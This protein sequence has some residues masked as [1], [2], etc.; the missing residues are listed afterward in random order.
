MGPGLAVHQVSVNLLVTAASDVHI[1]TTLLYWEPGNLKTVHS[2]ITK[3]LAFKNA[4][5]RT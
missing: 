5:L 2:T 3:F 1:L 4:I